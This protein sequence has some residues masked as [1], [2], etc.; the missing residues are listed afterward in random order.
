MKFKPCSEK[1]IAEANLIPVGTYPFEV[2]EAEDKLSKA[3]ND[4]IQVE[5]RVFMPD[6]RERGVLDW[7]MEKVAYKLFH[8][9][10][11]SGLATE[12]GNGTL[13]AADCVGKTGY[14]SIG[15][16]EDKTGQYPPR[17]NVKDYV[18]P[19]ALRPGAM[20]PK[21][22]AP[23]APEDRIEGDPDPY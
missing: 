9:C 8:F 2:M 23:A 16:Q 19:E 17:N 5:L 15:V 22:A 14:C 21:A 18:R 7:L 6:G 12:Y 11:Y 1:E 3:G 13:K 4:M 10:T 20:A